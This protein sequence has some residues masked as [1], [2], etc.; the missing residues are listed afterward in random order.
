MQLE[1]G[2]RFELRLAAETPESAAFEVELHLPEA[3][4]QGKATIGGASGS[5]DITFG[6]AEP[7]PAW[8]TQAVRAA[9]RTLFRER[10]AG[11][12]YPQRVTR[13]RPAPAAGEVV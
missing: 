1:E 6:A 5:V 7:P 9:L 3:S 11:K 13:W 4:W 12:R 8:C 2:V 10:G